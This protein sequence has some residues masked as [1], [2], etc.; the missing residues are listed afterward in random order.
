MFESRL[1]VT[2]WRIVEEPPRGA[3]APARFAV[4]Q[5]ERRVAW[6]LRDREAAVRWVERLVTPAVFQTQSRPVASR[7]PL[8]R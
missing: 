7:N 4:L 1:R 5:N 6:G 2:N 3:D 8:P